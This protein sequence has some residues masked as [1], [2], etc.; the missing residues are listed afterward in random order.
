[1]SITLAGKKDQLDYNQNKNERTQYFPS[2]GDKRERASSKVLIDS[3]LSKD[4]AATDKNK[5]A[6]NFRSMT[7]RL[8]DVVEGRVPS[9]E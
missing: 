1:M 2:L 8:L 6:T 5:V 9:A 4:V 7:L 3:L